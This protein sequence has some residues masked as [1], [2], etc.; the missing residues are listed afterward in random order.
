VQKANHALRFQ[1][2]SSTLHPFV[3]Q[4]DKLVEL[5]ICS[6]GC[7]WL[8][9]Y[10]AAS[11]K[12]AE[13]ALKTARETGQ[14]TTLFQALYQAHFNYTVCGNYGTRRQEG[15]PDIPA[16]TIGGDDSALVC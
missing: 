13:R 1:V 4:S 15:H 11:R 8:L 5:R 10:P 6:G 7:V 2:L 9:G 12:D 3:C 14:A 16:R